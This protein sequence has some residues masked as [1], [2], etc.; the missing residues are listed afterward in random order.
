MPPE[1]FVHEVLVDRLHAAEGRGG[2]ELPVRP[3]GRRRRRAARRSSGQRFGFTVEGRRRWSA[4][5]GRRPSPRPTSGPASPPATS[6]AAAEALGRPHR[7]EG[8]VVHGDRRGARA[9][10]SR[11]PTST[12]PPHAAIPADGIYA[13][14]FVLG[15]TAALAGGDLDRHQPDVLR[16]GAHRRGVRARRGRATSTAARV[17]R[18]LRRAAARD[19][20]GSTR[21]GSS[22]SRSDRDVDRTRARSS[23]P[24]GEPRWRRPGHIGAPYSGPKRPVERTKRG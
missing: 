19:R 21:R 5:D 2:G 13:G 24:A 3:P 4:D 20:T 7:V 22:S 9:G 14:W 10:L 15:G 16:P 12:P 1:E 23:G 17:G 11:P 6:R 18:G 8:V